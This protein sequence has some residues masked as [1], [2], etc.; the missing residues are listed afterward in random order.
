MIRLL[1]LGFATLALTGCAG[2]SRYASPIVD[3]RGVD[4]TKYANDVGECTELKRQLPVYAD[5]GAIAKCMAARGYTVID[6]VS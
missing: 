2:G 3:M 6:P 1:T 5:G 4:P